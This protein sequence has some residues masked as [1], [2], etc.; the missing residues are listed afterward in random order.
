MDAVGAVI[1]TRDRPALA[2]RAARNALVQTHRLA[3]LV[4]VDD[5]SVPRLRL[6]HDLASDAR[7]DLV[8]LEPTRGR[9]AARNVG[10]SA[11]STPLVAFLDDDDLWH[12]RK[13]AVQVAALRACGPEVA[14]VGTAFRLWS[15]PIR[16]SVP[17]SE[18]EMPLALLESFGVCT[19]TVLARRASL[20]EV[21]GF[22]EHLQ[23]CEDWDLW[24]RLSDRHRIIGLP[25]ILVERDDSPVPA[26]E[27][28][29]AW[30]Q[31]RAVLEP[32]L[33][34]LSR[35]ERARVEAVHDFTA[36]IYLA[37]IGERRAAAGLLL[38]AW[39]RD[40]RRVRHLMHCGRLVVGEPLWVRA[41]SIVRPSGEQPVHPLTGQT[42]GV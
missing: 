19:S 29:E 34:R 35:R 41:V 2:V 13:T 23:R 11:L 22:A 40:P 37:R 4:V 3:E 20:L 26:S 9:G 24:V 42:G 33:A 18:H 8:R 36:G 10:M 16:V 15:R 14:A 5:G 21:G 12:P 6:P 17:P 7:V 32:R 28:Y 38:R 31:M 39:G 27:L 25:E 1:A 30:R